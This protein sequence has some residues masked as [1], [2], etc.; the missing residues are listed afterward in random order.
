[1][2]PALHTRKYDHSS[3][4]DPYPN[5]N[6]FIAIQLWKF[7]TRS[8]AVFLVLSTR[9]PSANGSF[10]AMPRLILLCKLRTSIPVV[11]TS[12]TSDMHVLFRG[13]VFPI[14][15][16]DVAPASLTD[17]STCVGSFIPSSVSVGA[18]SLY[19]LSFVNTYSVP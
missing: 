11:D 6:M 1:M 12:H 17:P 2:T 3:C 9:R 14:H 4:Q 19:V 18:N 16:L 7:V 5:A 10:H 8:M 13:R 15:P